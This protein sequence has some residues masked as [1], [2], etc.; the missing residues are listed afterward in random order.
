MSSGVKRH[1]RIS[2]MPVVSSFPPR[3]MTKT[4][5]EPTSYFLTEDQLQEVIQKHGAP[6]MKL[7]EGPG[8]IC[9][10]RKKG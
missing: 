5:S 3:D 1:R 9:A 7:S 2:P 10:P 6:K 8:R 4:Y